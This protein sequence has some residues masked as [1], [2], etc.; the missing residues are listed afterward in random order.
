MELLNRVESAVAEYQPFYAQLAELEQKNASLVFDYESPKG[1]KEARS[2]VNTL[3]LTKGALERTRKAAKEESLRVGRAIDAEAKEI[4]ARIEAM[5][6][7]HQTAIDEIEQ[8]EKQRVADLAERLAELRNTGAGARTSGELAEAIAQLEPLVVGDDWQEFKPQALEVKDDLLRN[9]RVRHAEYLADEA[10]EAELARLRA[11]AA[12]RE[13][14]EREAAIV[15]AAEERAKAE[16]ARAAQEAEARAA[17]EREAAA[18]RELELKLAAETAERRRVEA[19]QRAEQERIDAAAR[20][21]RQQQ[22]AKEQAERQAK[23]AA[24]R[25]ERQAAEAVRRE[26]ERVAAEQAA[27]AAEQARREA[28]KAHKAKIN[29][30]AL[31]ALVAGGLSEECAKQCVTLIASGQVPAVSIAY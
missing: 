21:E 30:A 1:N 24:E 22:E 4:N 8:R 19:E 2:H 12:E 23:E 11:E 18:R 20:A 26:Q 14:L 25:A 5:I 28:N 3:R 13:R 29:R 9:L 15:R 10:K 27:A 16:A 6:T 7:V 31:A 17:A